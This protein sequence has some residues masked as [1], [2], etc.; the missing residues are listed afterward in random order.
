MKFLKSTRGKDLL[1]KDNFVYNHE[2]TSEDCTS[3]RCKV[4]TCQGRLKVY[5][6][7]QI[8]TVQHNHDPP[9]TEVENI[10]ARNRCIEKVAKT[11]YSNKE[12]FKDEILRKCSLTDIKKKSFYKTMS[13]NRKKKLNQNLE[14]N[15]IPFHLKYTYN[16]FL[17]T[18]FCTINESIKMLY[19][20]KFLQFLNFSDEW[21]AD[22]TFLFCPKENFQLYVIYGKYLKNTYPFVYSILNDKKE[23]TYLELFEKISSKLHFY[24]PKFLIIDMEK[25]AYNGFSRIF[26]TTKIFFC[27]THFAKSVMNSVKKFALSYKSSIDKTYKEFFDMVK[28][29]V[30]IPEKFFILELEKLEKLCI[31]FN[32]PNLSAFLLNFQKNHCDYENNVVIKLKDEYY[33]YFRLQNGISLTTN[34]AEGNNS[35]LNYSINF[36][37]PSLVT[38]IEK[39]IEKQAFVEHKMNENLLKTRP[40]TNYTME[41]Y[42][43]LLN[44]ISDYFSY[45]GLDLLRKISFIYRWSN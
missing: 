14:A 37:K 45:N 1:I 31:E 30:F 10:F 15:D 33:A 26:P 2:K 19:T 5:N 36:K 39:L 43:L 38:C 28:S 44:T 34:A 9:E 35:D 25:S 22:G 3:W 16:N 13:N 7:G 40:Q 18:R 4:R 41:K 29:L 24:C 8:L 21:I 6:N 32:D 17:F 42:N 23:T 27:L 12:I 11:N 20:D